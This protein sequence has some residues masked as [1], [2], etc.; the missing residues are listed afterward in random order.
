MP[1]VGMGRDKTRKKAPDLL[2]HVCILV[3]RIRIEKKE[4]RAGRVK[5]RTQ[6]IVHGLEMNLD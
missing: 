6:S 4:K 3:V 2:N 5:L 1:P